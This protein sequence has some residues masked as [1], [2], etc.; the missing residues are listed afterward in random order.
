MFYNAYILPHLDYCCIIWGN[1]DTCLEDKLLKLQKRAARLIL[2]KDIR[3]PSVELFSELKWQTF[4]DR[5]KFQ[6]AVLTYKILNGLA[7]DYLKSMFTTIESINNRVLRS[8][9]NFQLYTPRPNSELLRKSFSYS[10]SKL[11]NSI[12]TNVKNAKSVDQFKA[13]YI[14]WSKAKS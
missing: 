10:A 11:W 4:P 8:S 3:T 13:L 9:S 2:D 7:P 12:P 1:C 6:K 5:V 14:N